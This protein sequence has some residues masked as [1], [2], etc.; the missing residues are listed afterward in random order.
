MIVYK[1]LSLIISSNEYSQTLEICKELQSLF[2]AYG[3]NSVVIER[4]SSD[5]NNSIFDS[6]SSQSIIFCVAKDNQGTVISTDES[7]TM[8][9]IATSVYLIKESCN[10]V[11]MFFSEK[12]HSS[13]I[14]T[15]F[16]WL[17]RKG[18]VDL[19]EKLFDLAYVEYGIE[20]IVTKFPIS[21][22]FYFRRGAPR[23]FSE[24]LKFLVDE[25]VQYCGISQ[26]GKKQKTIYIA[27]LPKSG[28]TWLQKI[29]GMVSGYNVRSPFEPSRATYFYDITPLSFKLLPSY[30]YSI[31]KNHTCYTPYNFITLKKYV[32]KFIVLSRD[33]RDVA[34]SWY[35]HIHKEKK[36]RHHT[37]YNNLGKDA[38]LMHSIR[39]VYLHY[40]DW[41]L[42]WHKIALEN[43]TIVLMVTYEQL[44]RDL[45][46]TVKKILNFYQIVE[47]DSFYSAIK[48]TQLMKEVNLEHSLKKSETKRKGIIGDWKNHFTNNHKQ[49]FKETTGDLLITLGYE[50]D[51]NW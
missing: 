50:K 4:C 32:G 46:P 48:K 22:F 16:T 36:H 6:L 1:N 3:G 19:Q 35:F 2:V 40:T 15:L 49:F 23:S 39:M 30:A 41:I 42:N 25:L 20:K 44:N 17:I 33:L 21:T 5:P 13:T 18:F 27:G 34:I 11:E 9:S 14:Q 43:P 10:R 51:M 38:A 24:K 8:Q 26:A 31:V 47:K 37:L 7:C 45:L 28:T 12:Y 29:M